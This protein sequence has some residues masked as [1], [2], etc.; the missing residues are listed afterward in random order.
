MTKI[1][2]PQWVR[3][4]K[5]IRHTDY[6]QRNGTLPEYA[7]GYE[8]FMGVRTTKT[9]PRYEYFDYNNPDHFVKEDLWLP[10]PGPIK[11]YDEEGHLVGEGDLVLKD[12]LLVYVGDRAKVVESQNTNSSSQENK[13]YYPD[14]SIKKISV[15]DE[16]GVV[17][18]EKRFDQSHRLVSLKLFA[19]NSDLVEH[20]FLSKQGEVYTFMDW[21]GEHPD[22]KKALVRDNILAKKADRR[23]RIKALKRIRKAY[24]KGKIQEAQRIRKE[25]D[26]RPAPKRQRPLLSRL[27]KRRERFID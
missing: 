7:K 14:K 11:E 13:E 9:S 1:V 12:G 23:A 3:Q 24:R 26:A 10:C 27:F 21:Y 16:H 8:E 15:I 20:K 2:E 5:S 18:S 22:E 17:R 19:A 6:W 25:F 4:H